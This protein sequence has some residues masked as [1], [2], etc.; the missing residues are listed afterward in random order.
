LAKGRTFEDI[1]HQF[2]AA[3][4]LLVSLFNA[5]DAPERDQTPAIVEAIERAYRRA[6]AMADD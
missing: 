5:M 3:S 2:N 1:R 4:P 6:A